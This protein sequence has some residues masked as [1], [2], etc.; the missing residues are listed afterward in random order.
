MQRQLTNEDGVK[1][2]RELHGLV[3]RAEGGR[4]GAG[5]MD[6]GY[7]LT[8][9]NLLK[10]ISI[11][12]RLKFALP[13]IIMG[14]TGC[15]KS[16]LIRNLCGIL[17]FVLRTLNVHGGMVDSDVVTW[18]AVEIDRARR[19]PTEAIVI[20]F[21]E[22]NTCNCMGLFREI[23]CDRCLNGVPIPPNLKIIAA[24]N[25]YRLR[26]AQSTLYGGEE[27]AGLVFEMHVGSGHGE[28]V[29]TGIKDPLRNLV[30]RVHPL[31]EAMIDHIFDFGALS[32]ET[33]KLYIYA[34]LK[35]Q[36]RGSLD[37]GGGG[38]GDDDDD[39]D[40]FSAAATPPAATAYTAWTSSWA[41]KKST[42]SEFVEVFTE[43][44]CAA[45][46]C[47][48][49]LSGGERSAASLRD[50][51]RCCHVFKFFGA[52]FHK[53]KAKGE[54][55]ELADFWGVKPAARS[56]VRKAAI[57]SLAF[58]YH[59]RLPRE[60]RTV[61]VKA[62][63]EAWR[64]LQV[65]TYSYSPAPKATRG[66]SGFYGSGAAGFYG[67]G[68]LDQQ[69]KCEW[70]KLEAGAF[71]ATLHET[72]RSFTGE[73]N[74]GDGIALNEA[75]CE[76]LFMIL[77][78]T[79]NQIPIFVI[80][81]PGSSK[82]LAMGLIQ[83]NL[84]GSAS[85][86]DFLRSLPAVEVFPYQCS[87]LSTSAGI[88]QAFA[89]AQRYRRESPATVVV[90]LLDEVG[91]A[92]QSPHLPL[93]VLHKLLDEAGSN[94]SVVG[95]SN[96]A[97]DPAKMNRAVHLY[98]PAPTVEDLSLT[99][100]GMV[101]SANLK[102]YLSALAK[103]Y[104][105]VYHAQTHTDFWGL[106]EY[107][108]TVRAINSA[109]NKA[110][111]V[112]DNPGVAALSSS[113]QSSAL[114]AAMLLNAVLRNFGGR[115][116]ETEAVVAVFFRELGLPLPSLAAWPRAEALVRAN[117]REPS[118]RH[119][120]LLT[121]NNG[122]LPLVFDRATLRHDTTEVIFGSDFPLDQTDLQVCLDIQRVKLCMA[123]GTTVVLVH[124]ESLYESLYGT[125]ARPLHPLKIIR[126][127]PTSL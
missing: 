79:L 23:V 66:G 54:S 60:E 86:S 36:L 103:A 19:M 127:A 18:M 7:V 16:S 94:E 38:G 99:A 61:L 9:D 121:K 82:S 28:N 29:G 62:V 115:P 102:G 57:L 2:L 119:L 118:A 58:C 125:E 63:C 50:V 106:R 84:N 53:N 92:E 59:A 96:W 110:V 75:L 40:A 20:F 10:M 3:A 124:C 43:L 27:M 64:K 71:E 48:R 31:P 52:H 22:V 13:V 35:K 24:C 6:D 4:G 78:S 89:S 90:V 45:Q 85:D 30:Y 14:E 12:M 47:V 26:T 41:K 126:C 122:A 120:M 39:D 76:N 5:A 44:V 69:S 17:G 49:G 114:D 8:I 21:D 108:S 104:S 73:F 87:P 93:K 72:Q 123:V 98:R 68:Y 32:R 55:W 88:E 51:R 91:L 15:G 74:V 112:G 25:P 67:G 107:Y 81:K 70:L 113:T 42:F 46:E 116:N 11:A 34:M 1:R 77:V 83:Q 101:R 80:G 65:A 33:E 111:A 105:A 109:I 97:L 117:L 37:E 95:I 56:V 100:E